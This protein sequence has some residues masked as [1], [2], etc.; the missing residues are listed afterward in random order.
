VKS[1]ALERLRIELVGS[2]EEQQGMRAQR[3]KEEAIERRRQQSVRRMMNA[4]LSNGFSAWVELWE[5][6]SYAM[7]RL[8]QA[9]NKLH[10]PDRSSVFNDWASDLAA[11]KQ[12]AHQARLEAESKSLEVQLRRARFETSQLEVLKVAHL[13]ELTSLRERVER[14]GT[15]NREQQA[16][17]DADEELKLELKELRKQHK[18]ATEAWEEAEAA[19][20]EAARDLLSHRQEMHELMERLLANQRRTFE[21]D[22]QRMSQQVSAAKEKREGADAANE[23]AREE[24]DQ[25]KAALA[26][27]EKA[28]DDAVTEGKAALSIATTQAQTDVTRLEGRISELLALAERSQQE[29]VETAAASEQALAS[30]QAKAATELQNTSDALTLEAQRATER[31]DALGLELEDLKRTS[32]ESLANVKDDVDRLRAANEQLQAEAAAVKE[33]REGM[34]A[35]GMALRETVER[36][37][38]ELKECQRAL[39]TAQK[40]AQQKVEEPPKRKGTSVLGKIDIDESPDALPIT[41]QIASALRENAARVIDLFREMDA[42]GDGEVSK[43]EFREA[44]TGLGLEVPAKDVDSLF[45]SWDSDGGGSLDFKELQKILKSKPAT[46]KLKAA[47]A[48]IKL[49]GKK[50]VADHEG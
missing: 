39:K 40:A 28:M 4:G 19:K 11:A 17:I 32:A 9:A 29:A 6:R 38:K 5:A 14:L 18:L 16:R 34:E 15:S 1:V 46:S 10:A 35:D 13:D 12:A 48:A 7:H 33:A 50:T 21:E 8:Q 37:E 26:A 41:E 25:L 24:I 3:A 45:D 49:G 44:M 31:G 2:L 36:L 43:K 22:M 42:N 20:L 47:G 30:C 23:S 27:K